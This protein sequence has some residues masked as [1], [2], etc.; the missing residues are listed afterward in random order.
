MDRERRLQVT[1][2]V[3]ALV[4]KLAKETE[5]HPEAVADVAFLH[6]QK[7]PSWGRNPSEAQKRASLRY[8]K[9]ECQGCGEAVAR[10]RAVFHHLRR[11]IP[12]QHEPRNLLPYH[13]ECHDA[14]HGARRASLSKG[15]PRRKARK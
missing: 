11:R 4:E 15:T 12:N 5:C 14:K 13:P 7:H 10:E 3:S 1:Q 6:I 8:W 2:A 9:D